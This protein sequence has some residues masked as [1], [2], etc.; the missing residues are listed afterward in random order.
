M[1]LALLPTCRTGRLLVWGGLLVWLVGMGGGQVGHAQPRPADTLNLIERYQAARYQ[2]LAQRMRNQG[3]RAPVLPPR[4]ALRPVDR[5]LRPLDTSRTEAPDPR[6]PHFRIASARALSE[7]ERT[8]FRT[9]YADTRW[10]FLGAG[11]HLTFFD[12]TR[13]PALRARLE[14]QFGSP[15]A[16]L[17]DTHPDSVEGNQPQF[18]Y[19]FVVNDSIP[20]RVT[21]AN[22]PRDRGL[23]VAAPRRLRH[24]L[25]ALRAA[26]LRPLRQPRRAPYV[27]YYYDDTNRRW[28]RTGYDGRSFFLERIPRYTIVP[29]RRP[30]LDTTRTAG[31]PGPPADGSTTPR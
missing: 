14:A 2:M 13:T 7:L 5:L 22:G 10:S 12:T 23:I 15:T 8:W 29:G 31:T 11:T 19:W 4:S 25:R 28:Y 16:T 30:T 17:A 26:L 24:R 21:D 9:T 1:P 6:Q 18:E 3:V 27:D 20:V